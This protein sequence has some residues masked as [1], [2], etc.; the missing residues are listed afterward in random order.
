MRII[1]FLLL[2]SC[3][4]RSVSAQDEYEKIAAS[5]EL[6]SI[7]IYA[8]SEGFLNPVNFIRYTMEDTSLFYGFALL[9]VLSHEMY[10][11]AEVM[12]KKNRKG[13]VKRLYKQHVGEACRVQEAFTIDS[14]GY[15]F[16]KKGHPISETYQ[17]MMQF[18]TTP[19]RVCGIKLSPPPKGLVVLSQP[20]DIRQQK[21]F[22]KRFIFAPHT[23]RIEVP[24]MGNKMKTNIFESPTADFYNFK[25]D[26]DM[27]N[28]IT[29][30][31]NFTIEVDSIQYPDWR[32]SVLIK[33]MHSTF[34]AEDMAIIARSYD[35]YYPGWLASCD[36][37]IDIEMSQADDLLLPRQIH[38][39]GEWKFPTKG[40]DK[41]DILLQFNQV[42]THECIH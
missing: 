1:C 3:S 31:Y 29:P 23:L 39:R 2:I 15:F 38:Y 22:I 11:E 41:A 12:D 19:K 26:F 10:M 28:D 5:F 27:L 21:E 36:L 8:A 9:K 6:D 25:V 20:K 35:L 30:V 33:R 32:K 4:L 18:F 16:D 37:S 7:T 34:R 42:S 14:S 24:F 40:K 17:M 13:S